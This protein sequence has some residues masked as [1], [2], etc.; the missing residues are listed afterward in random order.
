MQIRI[1][2]SQDALSESAAQWLLTRVSGTAPERL[3]AL[4]VG[5]SVEA[6]YRALARTTACL[7]GRTLITIDEMHGLAADDERLFSARLAA[8]L[9]PRTGAQ[10]EPFD[11]LAQDP[12]VE[13]CRIEGLIDKRGLGVC[14]LGLGP[15]GHL[16]LNEPGEP[17]GAPSRRVDFIEQTIVHLGG[18]SAIS[19]STGGMTLSLGA[20]LSAESILL[21]VDGAKRE[22]VTSL[23]FGPLTEAVPASVLRLHP[24]VTVMINAAVLGQDLARWTAL[25]GVE[26][27]ASGGYS[28]I[29]ERADLERA[30]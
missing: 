14:V 24:N 2:E 6:P 17:F 21:I 16:A 8:L 7:E 13:A 11:S 27:E 12:D 9:L 20:L 25:P 26:V 19:P 1:A 29:A 10:L 3:I 5:A 30:G 4:A 28:R 22:A 23:V 15:N 18:I